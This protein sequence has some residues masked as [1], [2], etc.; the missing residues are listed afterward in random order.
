MHV[1]QLKRQVELECLLIQHGIT[2][3]P[4]VCN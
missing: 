2:I 4:N 3:L 1:V